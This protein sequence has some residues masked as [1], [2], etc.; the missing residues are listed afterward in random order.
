MSMFPKMEWQLFPPGGGHVLSQ[1]K[2]LLLLEATCRANQEELKHGKYPLLYKA[3]IPYREEPPGHED[4][5][6]I[7]TVIKKGWGDCEDLAAWLVAELREIFKIPCRPF[8]RYKKRGG[9]FRYHA[10]VVLPNGY[11]S[12][13]EI[14][15]NKN[16]RAIL[17][18]GGAPVI[19]KVRKPVFKEPFVFEDP[20][21]RLGM[22]G[23]RPTNRGAYDEIRLKTRD[24][25]IL[26]PQ[27]R[28][29]A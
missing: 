21:A 4:W 17:N 5:T 19:K 22:G 7:P 8:L 23:R 6:D 25:G 16:G 28:L 27:R 12:D 29:A 13:V 26:Q 2:L 1:Q 18:A 11:R 14:V 24:P 15:R 9:A 10:L 3:N 20:S